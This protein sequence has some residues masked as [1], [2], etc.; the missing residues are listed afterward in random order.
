M[1]DI[2]TTTIIRTRKYRAK[3]KTAVAGTLKKRAVLFASLATLAV[4]LT[5]EGTVASLQILVFND[6]AQEANV[7]EE[8]S[9]KSKNK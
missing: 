4:Q 8:A 9:R 2:E 5:Q 3:F 1:F 7:S 6:H